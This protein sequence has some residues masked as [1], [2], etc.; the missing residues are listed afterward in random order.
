MRCR[1]GSGD[2]EQ[3]AEP[4]GEV[5]ARLAPA[6]ELVGRAPSSQ[7][8]LRRGECENDR[9][10]D[11]EQIERLARKHS[12]QLSAEKQNHSACDDDAEANEQLGPDDLIARRPVRR[13][14]MAVKPGLIRGRCCDDQRAADAC[15]GNLHE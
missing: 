9:E 6:G 12:R 7:H 1:S 10:R 4:R 11:R 14:E 8:E 13:K 2:I 5:T 3:P 15:Q